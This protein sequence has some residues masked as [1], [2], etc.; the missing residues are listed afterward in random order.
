MGC[1]SSSRRNFLSR[2]ALTV[3]GVSLGAGRCLAAPSKIDTPFKHSVMGWC[4]GGRGVKPKELG[5]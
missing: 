5:E 3:G 2:A 4:F 1:M